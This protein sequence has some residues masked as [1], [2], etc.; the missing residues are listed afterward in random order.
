MRPKQKTRFL[1]ALALFLVA[2]QH[3]AA[4]NAQEKKRPNIVVI[5]TGGTIAG[6]ADLPAG[7]LRHSGKETQ[8]IGL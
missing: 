1:P 4:Q 7:P 8:R 3:S 2:S 6:A 5:A